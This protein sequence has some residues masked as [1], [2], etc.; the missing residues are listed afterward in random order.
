MKR[1]VLVIDQSAEI[2]D[3]VRT[4]FSIE[5]VNVCHAPTP[6]MGLLYMR[7]KNFSLIVI[8]L[9]LS[10]DAGHEVIAAMREM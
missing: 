6:E 10:E 7:Q 5:T 4:H 9:L 3:Y 8:D 1:E 2:F